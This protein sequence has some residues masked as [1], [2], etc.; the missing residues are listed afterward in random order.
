VKVELRR[1]RWLFVALVAVILVVSAAVIAGY[2]YVYAPSPMPSEVRVVPEDHQV[3]FRNV[4]LMILCPTKAREMGLCSL[5][6]RGLRIKYS[7]VVKPSPPVDAVII[8]QLFKKPVVEPLKNP[9]SPPVIGPGSRL[10]F[11]LLDSTSSFKCNVTPQG[12]GKYELDLAFIA[13]PNDAGQM[14]DYVLVV[15]VSYHGPVTP[16]MPLLTRNVN[17]TDAG[18]VCLLDYHTGRHPPAEIRE[19]DD[20]LGWF[21]SCEDA[22]VWQRQLLDIPVEPSSRPSSYSDIRVAS[23][24][25]R[26]VPSIDGAI[27][28]REWSDAARLSQQWGS[29]ANYVHLYVKNDNDFLYAAIDSAPLLSRQESRIFSIWLYFDVDYDG[30]LKDGRDVAY[31]YIWPSGLNGFVRYSKQCEFAFFAWKGFYKEH[32]E[33]LRPSGC[34]NPVKAPASIK[35]QYNGVRS[36]VEMKVR[37][38]G[39]DGIMTDVGQAVGLRIGAYESQGSLGT[40]GVLPLEGLMHLMLASNSLTDTSMKNELADGPSHF[41]LVLPDSIFHQFSC[42]TMVSLW[43]AKVHFP[44]VSNR[45]LIPVPQTISH[46]LVH[47]EMAS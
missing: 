5:D 20:P 31:V 15:T 35:G 4:G 25:V 19:S 22:L 34:L 33:Y 1:R 11:P 8:C 18:D 29:S 44:S 40:G 2:V 41:F 24:W 23:T 9:S 43:S 10:S 36:I 42:M 7:L 14:G 26:I 28:L 17:G 6:E 47:L 45:R 30:Q 46:P 21:T 32:E 3:P 37:L 16:W 39:E 27:H 13:D 12:D 38:H